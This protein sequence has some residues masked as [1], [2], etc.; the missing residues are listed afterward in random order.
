MSIAAYGSDAVTKKTLFTL[1]AFFNT[2][3]TVH[4]EFVP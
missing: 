2:E 1:T 3:G 4:S